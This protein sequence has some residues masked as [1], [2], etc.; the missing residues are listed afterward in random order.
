MFA[1]SMSPSEPELSVLVE[2]KTGRHPTLSRVSNG[3]LPKGCA[4]QNRPGGI[5]EICETVEVGVR[6]LGTRC[7]PQ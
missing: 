7:Q 4:D 2:R 3:V 1:A 6:S 5:G